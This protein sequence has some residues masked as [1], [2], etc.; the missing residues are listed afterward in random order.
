[1]AILDNFYLKN[2]YEPKNQ[3]QPKKKSRIKVSNDSLFFVFILHL[4]KAKKYP[5]EAS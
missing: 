1:M 4:K 5:H 2:K 3:F